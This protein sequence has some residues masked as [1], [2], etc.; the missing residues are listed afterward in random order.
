MK[1][2]LNWLDDRTGFQALMH[3]ALYE[4]VPGGAR[5]RY[6]WGS[7]LV[8]TFSVQL[9]TGLF[10]W[11]SYSPSSQTAW[12][13]VYYV[14][15]EM[16]FGW[17]LRGIHHFTAQ[18]MIVLLVV[19]LLQVIID[20][21]YKAPREVNFWLG[22]ILMQIVLGLSL[23]GYLLPWDQKGYWATKVATTI[24]GITPV[25]GEQV[26]ALAV[27]GASYGHHTLTRF[28]A[29]H[30]GL[31]PALLV[32]FL[33]LHIY[34]FRRHGITV[35][36]PIYRAD[37]TFWPDQMLK[38]AVAC[39]AVLAAV[40]VLCISH[41]AGPQ[42]GAELG[43]PAD[44]TENY[45]AA[46]P[47][48]YF[49]FLFQF[50]KYFPG[51]SEIIGAM[52][53]PGLVMGML[54]LMPFIGR[55]KLGHRFNIAFIFG[56]LIGIGVLTV[57]AWLEDRGNADY[58]LAVADA[59]QKAERV[60]ELAQIQGIGPA[61]AVQLL[62]DD[63]KTRGAALFKVKCAS[64]HRYDGHD[65]T[66]KSVAD[67]ATAADLGTFGTRDWIRGMLTEPAGPK[68]FGATQ[69]SAEVGARFT[70]GKM[71]EWVKDNIATKKVTEKELD[72]VV[73]FLASL[74]EHKQVGTLDNEKITTGRNLFAQGFGAVSESCFDCHVMKLAVDLEGNFAD[75]SPRIAPGAP[76]L[77]GYGS[78]Q[79]LR[80]FIGNPGDKRFYSSHNAMPAFAGSLTE[81]EINLIVDWLLHRWPEPQAAETSPPSAE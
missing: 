74:S 68:S 50:L 4:R 32:A 40:L 17:L 43:A 57:Q 36:D 31:L 1:R 59:D 58:R 63:P 14:Q 44:P 23:T 39:L 53:I 8:F 52:I 51:E 6:V 80:E 11:M 28:F 48:W 46:R 2:L 33:A 21:A 42:G 49:L 64:C 24:A 18:A 19:H 78:A 71:A 34:V 61:G 75:E 29:L 66:G 20:G 79:W 26:Q 9:V 16:L 77:S 38:D 5:W 10:L 22:L 7:T 45:S 47:E 76:E 69:N 3:E 35:P 25:V 70:A 62:R 55:W 13:S 15:H 65:G 12:E 72:A 73:E 54:A 56:I 30:A 81:R 60:K 41:G 67:A 27:G 37:T